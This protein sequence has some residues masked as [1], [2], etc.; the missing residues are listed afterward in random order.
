MTP[1]GRPGRGG[2][3]SGLAFALVSAASFGLSGALAR[4]LLDNGWTPGAVVIARVG[5]AAL[6]VAPFGIRALHGRWYVLRANARTL[7]VY[8]AVAVA[9][10]QFFYFSA[11]AHMEVAPALLI[12]FTAPAA[13]VVWLWL[14]HGER[15]GRVTVVGAGAGRAWA[16]CWCSTCCRGPTSTSPACCGRWPRWSGARRTS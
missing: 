6:V 10:T 12:E 7:L 2:P 9:S 1:H 3:W 15:P 8:G 13:V 4:P 11:V 16:W 14:R 5:L